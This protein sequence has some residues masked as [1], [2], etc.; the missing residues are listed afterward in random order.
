MDEIKPFLPSNVIP[1]SSWPFY[2]M[3]KVDRQIT[4]AFTVPAKLMAPP[5]TTARKP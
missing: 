5:S 3:R 1:L 2:F 4:E